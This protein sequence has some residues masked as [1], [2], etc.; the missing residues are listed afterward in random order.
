MKAREIQLKRYSGKNI[1]SNAKMPQSALKETCILTPEARNI[2]KSAFN[3]M[4]LSAR[5]GTKILKIA[6]TIADLENEEK[7]G[8][9]HIAEAIQ[10]RSLNKK[11]PHLFS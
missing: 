9:M 3:R 4:G 11:Y 7:I 10:F 6:R 1:F 5:A 2:L 8:V